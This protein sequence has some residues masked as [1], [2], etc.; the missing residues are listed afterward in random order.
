M[1]LGLKS[2]KIISD[3]DLLST[4]VDLM[5]PHEGSTEEA[6]VKAHVFALRHI[7]ELGH[8]LQV[9]SSSGKERRVDPLPVGIYTGT[10]SI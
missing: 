1:P 7:L 5:K 3:E 8:Y 6:L 4:Y 10:E 9:A 2:E